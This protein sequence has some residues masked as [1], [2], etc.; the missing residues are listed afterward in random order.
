MCTSGPR[1]SLRAECA[2]ACFV[3]MEMIVRKSEG[4]ST[5]GVLLLAENPAIG[6]RLSIQCE[7]AGSND[8]FR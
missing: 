4:L 7:S 6:E 3:G 1:A 2:R 8:A 5:G